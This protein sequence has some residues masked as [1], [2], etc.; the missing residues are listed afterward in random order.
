MKLQAY[1][2]E[3]LEQLRAILPECT[4]LLKSNGDFPL[5]EAAEL[6][7]YGSGARRTVKGGTGSGEVNSRYS[8]SVEEGLTHVG[9]VITTG[10]WMDG[11][12]AAYA[13][14]KKLFFQDL[15]E[16]AKREHA[17]VMVVGMGAVMPEP[18]YV[19]PLDGAGDV[20][21]YVLARISGEGNDR[22]PIP[23]DLLLT[24]TEKRD[25]L[26]LNKKYKKFLLVINAGGPVD[27]SPVMEVENILVLSQLGVD[28]GTVLGDLLLGRA[29]PSGKLTTT[30]AAW[31]DYP[32]IGTFGDPDETRYQ[33]G[34]Y[35]GYRYFDSVGKKAL[36]PFGHGLGYTAF[37][38]QE[39]HVTAKGQNICVTA[40]VENIGCHPGK[41]VLQLY[42]SVPSERLDQP[43]QT[44]AAFT[45][46]EELVPGA[47]QKVELK[48]SLSELASFDGASTAYVL[49]AGDYVLRLGNSS[50]ETVICGIVQLEDDVT[51]QKVRSVG[52]RPDFS[53]WKPE[54]PVEESVPENVPVV[55]VA[56]SDIRTAEITYDQ[57]ESISPKVQ[58]LSDEMLAY[59]NVGAFNPKGGVLSIIGNASTHVA[60]A[61]GETTSVLQRKGLP[62]LIM[63]DGPAGLRL[64]RDYFVDKKGV[65]SL[66]NS[67]PESM[68]ELLPAPARFFMDMISGKPKKNVKIEHQYATAIP[69]GTALAQSWNPDLAKQ[70]GDIVGDEMER[71]G[72]H[73]WL[74]PAL[75][76]HR[77]VLCGRN[78]EYFSE[79]P[80]ISGVFAA[81]V[82]E[83]V[84]KHP[85]CGVTIKH[86]AVNNQE[87]NRYGSNSQVS[88]RALR[89]IYLRGFAICVR[90]TKPYALMTSYN[91]LNGQHTSERRDLIQ[92][93]LRSECGYQG[94]VMTDWLV[95]QGML[96]KGSCHQPPT[97][98]GIAAAGGDLV[99]PGGRKDYED[100]LKGLK[101]GKL[102]RRQLEINAARVV[103]MA[104]KLD[105]KLNENKN[106]CD[107]DE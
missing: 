24:E 92:E 66:G 100:I 103:R 98:A 84:Q 28:T 2:K 106:T 80:L 85:G 75:N 49:E 14:A 96:S 16:K 58:A 47:S 91:L 39:S 42:V 17:N 63:A 27:L 13:E 59:I 73:L 4:V 107:S 97:A 104:R 46:T 8:V 78:F 93:F 26:S 99:M 94:I 31:E 89:E 1:E 62:P 71:F 88:E 87:T 37:N 48:F 55:N 15:K 64:S 36:F 90:R 11:Y 82:T 21:V 52:G 10:D 7:L 6:A 53:D 56:T 34:I 12:E 95:A 57:P 18:E 25:I 105:K 69:I 65:H 60:G 43:Y 41:E 35:V 77:S 23:G 67:M 32:Q 20:A 79:D 30:W 61:A 5:S 70:C 86:F 76:I 45:K 22:Q 81:A 101:S 50:T 33:E 40:T 102:T 19:L 83:G 68:L 29:Y 38:I 44:L 74:A 72:V 51:V 3:H 9:F 54:H